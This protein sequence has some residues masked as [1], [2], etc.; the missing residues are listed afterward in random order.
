MSKDR[1][2]ARQIALDV[3][4]KYDSSCGT[5]E[6]D[7]VQI[8]NLIQA[9]VAECEVAARNHARSYSDGDAAVGCAGAAN[10]VHQRGQHIISPPS[11]DYM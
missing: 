7:M 1:T 8:N 5:F 11:T 2:T 6:C 4:F 9:V 3:G 10:A